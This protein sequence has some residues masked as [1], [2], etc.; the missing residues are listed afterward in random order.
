MDRMSLKVGDKVVFGRKRGEKTRATV[1]KLNFKKAK[2]R[3]DEDRGRGGHRVGDPWTVSYT[4][5]EKDPTGGIPEAEVRA[6]IAEAKGGVAIANAEGE[7]PTPKAE[8]AI[9]GSAI[10][11][12]R[13]MTAVELSREGWVSNAYDSGV[14]VV[15]S[16]G[17]VLYPSQDSEG[18]GPGALFGCRKGKSF[19]VMPS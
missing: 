15:L 1:L 10:V 3:Q 11:S 17:A 5:I 4:L 7:E 13:P 19:M 6:A 9:I 14:A 16:N 2:V 18:N 8:D 12:I